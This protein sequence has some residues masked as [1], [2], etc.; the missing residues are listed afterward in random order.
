MVINDAHRRV[1]MVWSALSAAGLTAATITVMAR[2]DVNDA[3]S[4]C[5]TSVRGKFFKRKKSIV[6]RAQR[7]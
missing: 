2:L 1:L 7:G 6:S 5:Y 3:L 4:T